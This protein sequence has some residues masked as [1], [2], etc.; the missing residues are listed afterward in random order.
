MALSPCASS[1]HYLR[2]VLGFWRPT[3]RIPGNLD[4]GAFLSAK[5]LA[6]SFLFGDGDCGKHGK[7]D[8]TTSHIINTFLYL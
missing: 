8:K 1:L 4:C 6:W 3:D 2:N 5:R 7:V